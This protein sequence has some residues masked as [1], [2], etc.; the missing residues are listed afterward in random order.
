MLFRSEEDL[1]KPREIVSCVTPIYLASVASGKACRHFRSDAPLRYA[2]GMKKLFDAVPK[3]QYGTIRTKVMNCFSSE[4][5]FYYAQ[6]GDQLISPK[7]QARISAVF[8]SAGFTVPMFDTYEL[9]PD[10]TA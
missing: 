4:R 3:G 6:R 5:V 1:S 7:E 8:K 10:W 9:S 2:R